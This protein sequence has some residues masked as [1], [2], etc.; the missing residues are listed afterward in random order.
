MPLKKKAGPG[1]AMIRDRFH[2]KH[3]NSGQ[4]IFV[5][6]FLLH[7]IT[8]AICIYRIKELE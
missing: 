3:V 7:I 5:S 2:T 1:R 6:L 8:L 4:E